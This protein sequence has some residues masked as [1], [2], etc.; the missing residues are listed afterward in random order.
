MSVVRRVT[1]TAAPVMFLRVADELPAMQRAW[2][3]LEGVVGLRERRFYGVFDERAQEYLVCAGIRPGD[4][5]GRFGL[6]VGEVAGGDYLR[7]EGEPPGVYSGIGPGFRELHALARADPK[8]PDVEF[9]RRRTEVEL[10]MPV[11]T[12]SSDIG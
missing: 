6:E 8:R 4:P 2:A 9:Y 1:R 12:R 3:E 7:L 10:L 5:P 11:I